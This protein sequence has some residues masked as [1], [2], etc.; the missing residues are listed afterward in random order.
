ML[1]I[2]SSFIAHIKEDVFNIQIMGEK[3]GAI[4]DGSQIFT[5]FNDYMINATPGYVGRWDMWEYKMRHFVEVVR[6]G[7]PNEAPAEHGVMVQKMLDGV[8]ASAAAGREV[9]IK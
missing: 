7:R 2:E 9:E 5:D 8:Y 1:T 6:D 4:W 3:G